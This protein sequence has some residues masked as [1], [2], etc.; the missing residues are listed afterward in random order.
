MRRV[1]AV[2]LAPPQRSLSGR[3]PGYQNVAGWG[4]HSA[5]LRDGMAGIAWSDKRAG[6]ALGCEHVGKPTPPMRKKL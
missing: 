2:R 1:P 6:D 5:P 4:V 3:T